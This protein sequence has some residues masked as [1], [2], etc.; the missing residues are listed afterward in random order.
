[1]TVKLRRFAGIALALVALPCAA[2]SEQKDAAAGDALY[3]LS[4]V[5]HLLMA[6]SKTECGRFVAT[7]LPP[8]QRIVEERIGNV[9]PN[10]SHQNQSEY[11]SMITSESHQNKMRKLDE[12]YITKVIENSSDRSGGIAFACGTSFG[13]LN[14]KIDE[15]SIKYATFLSTP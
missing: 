3:R 4:L 11:R 14:I 12:V 13:M 9:V 1:M 15:S 5:K 2:L 7:V 6:Y 10:L 8:I